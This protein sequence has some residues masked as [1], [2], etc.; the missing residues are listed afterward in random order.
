VNAKIPDPLAPSRSP[1]AILEKPI[2]NGKD[3]KREKEARKIVDAM[4]A[5]GQIKSLWHSYKTQLQAAVE[6]DNDYA[7]GWGRRG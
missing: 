5:D 2:H 7:N 3:R 6:A 1:L 4:E